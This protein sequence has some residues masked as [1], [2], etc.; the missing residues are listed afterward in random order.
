MALHVVLDTA[1]RFLAFLF[2]SFKILRSLIYLARSF[3]TGTLSFIIITHHII[4]FILESMK[5]YVPH[6]PDKIIKIE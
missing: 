5:P 1:C 3:S 6:F 2:G 4:S